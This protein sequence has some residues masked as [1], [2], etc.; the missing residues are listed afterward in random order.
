MW[1]F[2]AQ[3]PLRHYP[4][5]LSGLAA[6]GLTN[7]LTARIPREI[8]KAIDLIPPGSG[9]PGSVQEKVG[10]IFFLALYGVNAR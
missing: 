3:Y 4:W 5:Y 8:E 9:L 6:L 1:K 10:V 7:Y 2:I